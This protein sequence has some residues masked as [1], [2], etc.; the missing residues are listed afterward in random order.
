[1]CATP[2]APAAATSPVAKVS[3]EAVYQRWCIHCHSPGRGNPGTESLQ[4]KYGGK[5]PAVL[6]KRS[7]LAPQAVALFVRQGVLSMAPF[8]KTE[9]TDAELAALSAYVA[10]GYRTP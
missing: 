7:D 1:P 3:G 6:L 8:R 2:A 10:K 4:V 9:I 5:V